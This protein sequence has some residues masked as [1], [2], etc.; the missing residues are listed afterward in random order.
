MTTK[1]LPAAIQDELKRHPPPGTVTL[2]EVRAE[3]ASRPA[4]PDPVAANRITS[5]LQALR[6][7]KAHETFCT[8]GRNSPCT[9]K[10]VDEDEILVG[11]TCYVP[12]NG[13]EGTGYTQNIGFEKG[14]AWTC[15]RGS[16]PGLPSLGAVIATAWCVKLPQ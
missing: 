15:S 7:P 13:S 2:A 8:R 14:R 5:L 1:Q 6:T 9:A 10:C 4:L 11:G 12:G 3:I 16:I